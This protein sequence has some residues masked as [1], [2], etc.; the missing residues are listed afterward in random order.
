MVDVN[1]D[2]LRPTGLLD[3]SGVDDLDS[4]EL[5]DDGGSV[6]IGAGVTYTR[7]LAEL[8]EECPGLAAA[9]R[10]IGSPQIR[11]RGTIAGN[12][13][14]ASPAGD[15]HPPLLAARAT[16]EVESVDRAREIPIDDFF[17]GPKRSALAPDELIR[18]VRVPVASGP[19]QFA[20]IGP[21]NAMV[22]ATV[23][24][25]I[26]ID[27]VEGRVGTGIG[28]AG[29]TPLRA[30]EAEALVEAVVADRVLRPDTTETF[31]RLVAE[32]TSPIDDQRGTASYRRQALSVLAGRCL[33]WAWSELESEQ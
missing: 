6:R 22:I 30:P 19:R 8:A 20:K 15:C 33:T 1:F 31:G 32:V 25:A 5:V 18:A 14:T 12:L 26:S 3:L 10:T 29:P 28:S 16:V 7:L 21:R 9:A 2:R 11:N 27:P 13:A 23:S 24:F 17:L 4:W